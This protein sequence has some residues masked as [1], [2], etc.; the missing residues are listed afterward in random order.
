MSQLDS[1]VP[2]VLSGGTGS[3]LWPLSRD[4]HPKQLLS[5]TDDRSMLQNTVR[6]A[7]A[8]APAQAPIIV[9]NEDHRFMVAEQLREL[10]RAPAAI[11]LEPV[12]RNTAPAIA[13]AALEAIASRGEDALLL[14]LAADH[15]IGDEARFMR[16]VAE[17]AEA[18]ASGRC[19]TFGIVPTHAE[20]GF[21][22]LHAP[23]DG[24]V[25]EVAAF[26]EKPDLARAQTFVASGEHF[27]NS[28]MFVLPARRYLELLERFA[29][30][31]A[32]AC[33]QAHA[34]AEIDLD[35]VRLEAG[36]FAASPSDSIDYAV[37]E[38][39]DDALMVALDAGW[40]DVGSWS[41]LWSIGERDEAGNTVLGDVLTHDVENSYLRS[42]KRLVSAVG[43]RDL[44]VIETADAV[45]VAERER[46][47]DVKRIVEQLKAAGRTEHVSPTEVFRPWGHHETLV[48]GDDFEVRQ[49][50]VHAGGRLSLQQH[51]HRSE[52][53]VVV[54]GTA[55]VT[56]GEEVVELRAG[57]ST[58]IAAGV[59]H[60]L[61][62]P[63]TDP[64]DLIEVRT[65]TYLGED[66][67][68]RL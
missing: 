28:G 60:Q 24:D 41:A 15:V 66:D 59:S 32:S 55:R 54:A 16:A 2:V 67:I 47:Q 49:L 13:V 23:G 22:Y 35:F 62:N 65:G 42:E 3:R 58:F 31:I 46:V 14:V 25:R 68:E 27:W 45:L 26:V 61:E 37:M 48:R 33:A 8:A 39:L 4:L 56:R 19:V 63:G 21:G 36:A 53:W 52:H 40:D 29:P 11:L 18:A 20:T 44:V 5:L 30:E 34:E 38:R 50:R 1:L 6:R 10:G 64:L 57:Q 12:G 9:C 7:D 43:V 51:L 17:A